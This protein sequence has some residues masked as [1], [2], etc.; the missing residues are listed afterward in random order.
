MGFSKST[1][2]LDLVMQE[3]KAMLYENDYQTRYAGFDP[4]SAESYI[5]SNNVQNNNLAQSLELAAAVQDQFRTKAQRK[6]MGVHQGNL[7]VLWG[8]TSPSILIETGFI[9]NPQE[10][11]FLMSEN[12]QDIIASAIFTAVREY[13]ELADSRINGLSKNIDTKSSTASNQQDITKKTADPV[14]KQ[15]EPEK[16]PEAQRKQAD[17]VT[18]PVIAEKKPAIVEKPVIQDKQSAD[19]ADKDAAVNQAAASPSGLEYRVQVLASGKKLAPGSSEFKGVKDLTEMNTDGMYKYLSK[20][21]TDYEE[22]LVL[23]RKLASTFKGA[24]I[25]VYRDGQRVPANQAADA[26]K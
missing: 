9:S 4:T 25:V 6:D 22:A 19:K 10:E 12:G 11:E 7:V 20:P 14:K 18:K 17:T 2:N 1:D 24:F 3:N 21:V 13:K 26:K 5:L 15:P 8:C 16:K 23:R